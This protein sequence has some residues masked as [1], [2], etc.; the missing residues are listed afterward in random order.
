MS[1]PATIPDTAPHADE[2]SRQIA[3][4]AGAGVM[5]LGMCTVLYSDR[6]HRHKALYVG[7]KLMAIGLV[8][9]R[10]AV[11]GPAPKPET[12]DVV[13]EDVTEKPELNN[14]A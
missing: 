13:A 1:T 14:N 5:A 11:D 8:M 12:V 10:A 4:L 6:R 3:I 2:C 7:G 9:M